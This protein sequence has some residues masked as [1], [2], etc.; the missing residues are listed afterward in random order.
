M[1]DTNSSVIYYICSLNNRNNHTHTHK[2]N[3]IWHEKLQIEMDREEA[4]SGVGLFLSIIDS[5]TRKYM[6]KCIIPVDNLTFGEQYN[7]GLILN[8]DGAYLLITLC[9]ENYNL[10]ELTLFLRNPDLVRISVFLV[11]SII[12]DDNSNQSDEGLA[13]LIVIKSICSNRTNDQ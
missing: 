12:G 4:Q 2:R 10:N 5:N 8:K 7:L 13:L 9:V 1:N 11:R 3:I 6:G